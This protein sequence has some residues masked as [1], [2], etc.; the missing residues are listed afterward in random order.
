MQFKY[1]STTCPGC[2]TGCGLN[3]IVTD[4][5]V[6]G[7]APYHRSAVNRGKLCNV[8]MTLPRIIALA[9]RV[10][11]PMV[12]G[13]E[14]TLDEAIA[15]FK[16]F[17]GADVFISPRLTNE[18]IYVFSRVAKEI[19]KSEPQ[20]L[21]DVNAKGNAKLSDISGAD[22][23]LFVGDCMKKLPVTGGHALRAKDKGA[24]ILYAGKEG[25]YTSVQADE[26]AVLSDTFEIPATMTEA[27]KGG[28]AAVVVTTSGNKFAADAEKFAKENGAKFAVL[29]TI[30]NGRGA[31][32]LGCKP[33]RSEAYAKG[34]GKT[35]ILF[36]VAPDFF[37]ILEQKAKDFLANVENLV[38]I[39]C[40]DTPLN[41]KAK[42]VIPMA[43]FTEFEGS[44]VNWE[45]K[46]QMVNA[47]VP[48]KENRPTAHEIAA[49]LSDGKIKFE[50]TAA[51]F[52]E[53][54]A[55][56]PAF[57]DTV[58]AVDGSYIKEA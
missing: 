4:E 23:I 44:F 7:V 10:E 52:E 33:T 12:N 58:L 32:A 29:Y 45:G 37:E 14:A 18:G 34:A 5:G 54:K 8:G 28:K 41:A 20:I 3:Q 51:V 46:V 21:I 27:V 30:S 50:N 49:K 35:L 26:T 31:V 15:E 48:V 9:P 47:A 25:T 11:K 39:T 42:V 16:K 1:V 53:I 22:V 24:K 13:K 19:L 2:G 36:G 17:S 40:D 38:L 55:K 43:T 6:V 57:K 56:V